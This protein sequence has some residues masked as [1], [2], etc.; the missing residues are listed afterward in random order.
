AGGP[1]AAA[2][3]AEAGEIDRVVIAGKPEVCADRVDQ[4][5]FGVVSAIASEPGRTA[6]R[7][8]RALRQWLIPAASFASAAVVGVSLGL[9]RPLNMPRNPS[10][11][12]ALTM[13]LDAGSYGPDWVL[14]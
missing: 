13:I 4:A 10:E 3:L 6:S 11:A 5:I 12:A 14:R 7:R 1:E 8:I 9:V 2:I